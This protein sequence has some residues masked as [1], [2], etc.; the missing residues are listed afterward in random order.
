LLNDREGLWSDRDLKHI[1][2]GYG[3]FVLKRKG[4][5]IETALM[6]LRKWKDNIYVRISLSIRA[7]LRGVR[8]TDYFMGTSDTFKVFEPPSM[9]DTSSTK[10][11]LNVKR[12]RSIENLTPDPVV[13]Y[14]EEH[15]LYQ[16]NA[17][18][19]ESDV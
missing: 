16:R 11:R 17:E 19:W 4:T 5:D 7:G 18:D 14:I 6:S 8:M 10:V 2:G 13:H 9:N 15:G 1:L 3:A 12:G